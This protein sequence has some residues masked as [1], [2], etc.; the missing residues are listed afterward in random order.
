[1]ALFK[2]GRYKMASLASL[3]ALSW[4]SA[5]A[6]ASTITYDLDLTNTN[7]VPSYTPPFVSVTLTEQT[8][9]SV[10]GVEFTVTSLAANYVV[11]KF[12]FNARD[13]AQTSQILD[14]R[15][16]SS[17]LGGV[18]MGAGNQSADGFGKFDYEF[19]PNLTPG[20]FTQ[21]VWSFTVVAQSSGVD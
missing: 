14:L 20:V 2:Q 3:V 15:V 9:G 5:A 12:F 11:D 4:L 13:L 1:M 19:D 17:T 10:T 6:S 16:D 8:V 18:L 7:G 21:S